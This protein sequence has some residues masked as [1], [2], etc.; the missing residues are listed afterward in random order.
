MTTKVFITRTFPGP[1]IQKLKEAGFDIE[2]NEEGRALSK[3]EII[4]TLTTGQHDALLSMLTD[5]ID[6]EVLSASPNLKIVA[7]YAVGYDNIDLEAAKEAGVTITN[8]PGVLT[9]AVAEHTIA[10]MFAIT[11][12]IAEADTFI[13]EGGWQ[14]WEPELLLGAELAGKTLGLIGTGR[15]GTRVGRIA[16]QGLGMGIIYN[17][18]EQSTILEKETDAQYAQSLDVL[19][20]NVDIVSIH[21]PLTEKTHHIIGKEEL[22]AM[23][24][25]AYLI[26]TARGPVID[27]RALV[28]ALQEGTIAGAALDVFENEPELTPGL[29]SLD[30][31]ILTP[32]LGSASREARE[33]MGELAAQSITDMLNG[34]EPKNKVI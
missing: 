31:V 22:G 5:T 13:R 12:R 15:I 6:K 32:H 7:N 4:E 30:N 21:V 23:K 3:K 25:T 19:L 26:N 1:G 10:L 11:R 17:D 2:I 28:K 24:K 9:N 8:T 34:I 33:Q 16:H 20:P 14:A 18:L 29:T 27:E